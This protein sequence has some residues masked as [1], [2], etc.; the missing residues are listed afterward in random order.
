MARQVSNHPWNWSE[1]DYGTVGEYCAACLID[2]NPK[3]SA[4]VKALCK[5]PIRDP[6]KAG[7]RLNRNGVRAAAARLH[8]VD[9]PQAL[10]AKAR[11][12]LR[13]LSSELDSS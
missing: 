11:E 12:S 4:K 2:A 6:V 13:K 3:G 7:G 8:Q 10:I 9:A 1:A 5:L